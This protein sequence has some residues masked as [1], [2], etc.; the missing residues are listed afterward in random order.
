MSLPVQN[1]IDP[2]IKKRNEFNKPLIQLSVY[3]S[4]IYLTPD[5]INVFI[6]FY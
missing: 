4:Y 1:P 3:T 5:F 6:K 2:L